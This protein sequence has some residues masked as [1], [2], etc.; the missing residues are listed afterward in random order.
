MTRPVG[1]G[2]P[3]PRRDDPE[4]D[5][6]DVE[7]RIEERYY[8][9]EGVIFRVRMDRLEQGAEYLRKGRWVWTPITSGSVIENPHA[10]PLSPV[11]AQP[12]RAIR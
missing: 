1:P 2:E 12:Y 9:L 6:V 10:T 11:E 3:P 5:R 8:R 4:E 7:V